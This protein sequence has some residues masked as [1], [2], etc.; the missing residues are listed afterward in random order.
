MPAIDRSVIVLGAGASRGA[1]YAH[2]VSFHLHSI[3]IFSTSCSDWSPERT[4]QPSTK[5]SLGGSHFRTITVVDGAR[6]FY[7]SDS[8]LPFGEIHLKGRYTSQRRRSS[9]RIRYL[10]ECTFEKGTWH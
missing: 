3:L 2:P 4:R 6:I 5:Y 1:S 10:C 8:S 9:C 7:S